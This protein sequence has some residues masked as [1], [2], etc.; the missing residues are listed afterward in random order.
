MHCV[1]DVMSGCGCCLALSVAQLHPYHMK[2]V[3]Y[4]KSNQSPNQLFQARPDQARFVRLVRAS[5]SIDGWSQ[6]RESS[7]LTD[8]P[9]VNFNCIHSPLRYVR[10]CGCCDG[11]WQTLP[12]IFANRLAL[13][14]L[15]IHMGTS[16][17]A[18]ASV[19]RVVLLVATLVLCM[20][21]TRH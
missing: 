16:V 19:K 14:Q 21:R 7:M 4:F 1:C 6:T 3:F 10:Y 13:L 20:D 9:S 15:A 5:S 2:S 8:H 11:A 18:T 12:K 17:E